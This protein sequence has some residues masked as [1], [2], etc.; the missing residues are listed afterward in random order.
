MFIEYGTCVQPINGKINTLIG[1]LF[2]FEK[3]MQDNLLF[4]ICNHSFDRAEYV[5]I[6]FFYKYIFIQNILI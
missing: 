5:C 2:Q 3:A 6:S 4:K 1:I